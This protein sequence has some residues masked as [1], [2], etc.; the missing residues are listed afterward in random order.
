[1]AAMSG[2]PTLSLLLVGLATALATYAGGVITLRLVRR[3]TLIF[4]VTSGFVLGLALFDLLP[5]ALHGQ[6]G[7]GATATVLVMALIGLAAGLLLHHLPE[8]A[9]PKASAGRIALLAH[10]LLDG[11]GIG[12]AFQI[13][14]T[15]GWIVAAAVLAHDLA[16]GANMAGL[17]LAHGHAHNAPRWLLANSLAPLLGI[18]LGQLLPMGEAHFALLL[19]LFSGSFLYIGLFEL[20]PRSAAGE[21]LLRTAMASGAGLVFMGSVIT[22]AHG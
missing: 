5:E 14:P 3:S 1:M 17:S 16:D 22:L 8:T 9:A 21:G 18:V 11:V 15:T 12:L 19:A 4:G 6:T 2:S 10:S 13:S 20:W 7:P